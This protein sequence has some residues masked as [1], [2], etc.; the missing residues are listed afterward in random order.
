MKKSIFLI[1]MLTIKLLN[2]QDFHMNVGTEGIVGFS[3]ARSFGKFVD[4]YNKEFEKD[5]A[6]KLRNIGFVSGYGIQSKFFYGLL[7]VAFNY[8]H[9]TGS[10]YA[11]FNNGTRRYFELKENY[12]CTN[13][14]LG[15]YDA[16]KGFAAGVISVGIN[17][18]N[19]QTYQKYKD[20][21]I[22]MGNETYLSG[23]YKGFAMLFSPQVVG[24]WH[25]T[26][27][28]VLSFTLT[29]HFNF[30]GLGNIDYFNMDEVGKNL[31]LVKAN[32]I[33]ED[34]QKFLANPN[35]GIVYDDDQVKFNFNGLKLGIGLEYNL[36]N[37]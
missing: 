7:Y 6:K 8:S 30:F 34:Y 22:S 28:L 16:G 19:V 1:I 31:D 37:K 10:S 24:G 29:Y 15:K 26:E 36:I 17:N 2:A 12:Y 5:L 20:G 14:G 11:K 4:S 3:N 35:L 33:P 13:V 9:L 23:S 27:H 18:M 32:S 21:T 25:I